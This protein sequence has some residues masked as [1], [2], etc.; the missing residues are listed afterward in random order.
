MAPSNQNIL[1]TGSRGLTNQ[2]TAP[3]PNLRAGALTLYE[4]HL[5]QAGLNTN[6]S[7]L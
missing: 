4:G 5:P 3:K 6:R 7:D 1:V 2:W